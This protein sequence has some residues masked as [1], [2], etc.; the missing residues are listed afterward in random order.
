M[1]TRSE[2]QTARRERE[3]RERRSTAA[4]AR[5]TARK[6][7]RLAA[8]RAQTNEVVQR[9]SVRTSL[10]V[11]EHETPDHGVRGQT[12]RPTPAIWRSLVY[13]AGSLHGPK[14]DGAGRC[15]PRPE[16]TPVGWL[17]PEGIRTART[18]SPD[19]P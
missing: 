13:P 9:P 4:K 18:L 5:E 3:K 2:A 14:Y 17:S 19:L 6:A 7:R 15:I 10:G 11:F 1:T 12:D 8:E 16:P